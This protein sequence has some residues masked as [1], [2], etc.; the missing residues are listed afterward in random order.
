M[1][2]IEVIE[3]N[4][5]TITPDADQCIAW[6]RAAVDVPLSAWLAEVADA[7]AA[8]A[9][10]RTWPVTI[11]LKHPVEFGD[12]RVAS[13]DLRRG[14]LRDIKGMK[15]GG[16]VAADQLIGIA[17][18]LASQPLQVIERL[19]VDDAGEVMSIALDFFGRCLG[20]GRKR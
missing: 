7:A 14:S 3:G 8:T 4:T 10:E 19:D 20:A 5:I 1:S 15:L 2:A 17:A 13:L 12:H 9:P 11:V 6:S 16:E 18:R